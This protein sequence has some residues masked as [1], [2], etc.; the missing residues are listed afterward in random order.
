[1]IVLPGHRTAELAAITGGVG[2]PGSVKLPETVLDTHPAPLV[3]T[4]LYEPAPRFGIVAG[5]EGAGAEPDAVPD[6][7]IVPDPLPFTAIDPVLVA[8]AEGLVIAPNEIAG[9]GLTVSEV[10]VLAAL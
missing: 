4:I 2:A 5:S 6:Q 10:V 1:M 7:E 8:H 3:T 9:V